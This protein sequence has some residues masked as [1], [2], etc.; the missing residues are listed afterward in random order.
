MKIFVIHKDGEPL[1]PCHP[2]K[3]RILLKNK[4]A[5]IVRMIPFTIQLLKDTKKEVKETTLGIDPGETFGISVTTKDEVLFEAKVK[6][7]DEEIKKLLVTRREAR[8]TRR[9][10]KTRYRKARFLNRVRTKKK[11]W[12]A[13]SLRTMLQTYESIFN[14]LKKILPISKVVIEYSSFDIQKLKNPDIEGEEYQNGEQKGFYN[15]REYV[16]WRD[17][18]VCQNCKGKSGDVILEAHHIIH[19]EDGGSDRPENLITLCDTCHTSYH[20]GK[21]QLKIKKP[22]AGFNSPTKMNILKDR[23][24]NLLENMFGVKNVSKTYGYITKSNRIDNDLKKDHHIDA[25]MISGNLLTEENKKV[26]IFQKVR[27]HNR[28]IYKDKILKGGKKKSNQCPYTIKNFHRYDVI[29]YEGKVLYINGLRTRGQFMYKSL[30]DKTF[31]TNKTCN[32]IKLIQ[33]RGGFIIK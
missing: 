10:R 24:M 31:V 3:A 32:K 15:V 20:K 28:K 5:K 30:E 29:K 23:L 12:I 26:Y 25:R 7:R 27:R 2:A 18:H 21:I 16:L 1:M 14:L 9:G 17:G 19:R 4:E 6:H 13:P 33:H 22:S 11:G 8:R